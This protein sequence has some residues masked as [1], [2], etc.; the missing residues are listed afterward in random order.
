M[1]TTEV[2]DALGELLGPH[3]FPDKGDG[4]NPRACPSCGNGTLSLKL[5]KFGAFI[6][7]SNYPECRYTRQLAVPVAGEGDGEGG[8]TG[9]GT[10]KLGTDPVSGQEVTV[11]DGR[12]GPYVQLGEG[13]KPKRVSLPKGMTPPG[14]E[15][16][17]ALK[18]LELPKQ[19]ASHPETGEPILV[20]I[21]K[22]GPYVQHGRTYANL[23]RDD[24]VLAVGANRAIDLIVTKETK[25]GGPALRRGGPAGSFARRASDAR[26]RR[27]GA[28][29]K[30]R[31]LC[32]SWQGQR[33]VAQ[34]YGR[35]S[36][37][38]AAGDRTHRREGWQ[39]Q[40][41]AGTRAG[42]GRAGGEG[43]GEAGGQGRGRQAGC[44]KQAGCEA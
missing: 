41:R 20:G 23:E 39:R 32:Q 43:Q 38:V 25:G 8:G 7:C 35:G 17:R 11:R 44:E 18:L 5:G 21:G 6:G 34:G 1:R 37:D 15:L 4:T 12:F 30:I 9:D 14:L 31:A 22:Y 16:E 28:A 33:H 2:L 27:G 24:D 19:V 3:I 13:E 40:G 29:G 42:Q 10:R 36:G 26:R